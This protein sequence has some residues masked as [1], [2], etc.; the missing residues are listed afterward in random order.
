[1]AAATGDQSTGAHQKRRSFLRDAAQLGSGTA[2]AQGILILAVPI[3]ARLYDPDAFGV[4]TVFFSITMTLSVVTGL[5]Y[6]LAILLPEKN[7]AAIDL[8]RLHLALTILFSVAA[9]L[10]LW[11]LRGPLAL[12]LNTPDLARYAW[13][14]GI[15]IF[16]FGALNAMISW[17]SRHERFG[18]LA[19]TRLVSSAGTVLIQF[20]AGLLASATPGGLI[21]GGMLGKAL[22]SALQAVRICRDAQRS[23][24]HPVRLTDL[25]AQAN[26]YRKFPIYNTWSALTNTLSWHVP[27][28]LLAAF[29]TPTV[30]GWYGMGERL[31]RTPMSILGRAV[32][33]VFLQRGAIAHREATLAELFLETVRALARLGIMP[34]IVLTLTGRDIFTCVLGAQWSEAGLYIQILGPWAFI[35]FVTSPVSTVLTITE[36]QE[37]ALQ[38]NVLI[39]V[40]RIASFVIGGLRQDPL[41]ALALFTSTGIMAYGWVL[42]WAGADAGVRWSRTLRALHGPHTYFGIVL[43]VILLGL[44]HMQ[45]APLY[46]VLCD[47]LLLLLYYGYIIRRYR[48]LMPWRPAEKT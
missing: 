36:H 43:V 41:L 7:R 15:G 12:V 32:G 25:R 24:W 48:H 35:W 20:A 34:I 42:L 27:A 21:L 44:K 46:V 4:A 3:L 26:R 6:E 10:V 28:F 1:M 16:L 29:F 45:M 14:L 5:R 38:F 30:V 11:F 19:T 22:E 2:L 33:Q 31:L 37:K 39:L 17:H 8:L 13:I 23:S 40:T 47:G 18:L 9:G